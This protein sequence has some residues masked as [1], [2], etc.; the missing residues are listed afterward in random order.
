M[1]PHLAGKD[2]VMRAISAMEFAPPDAIA[3]AG[4]GKRPPPD[5]EQ[6]RPAGA[7]GGSRAP[8]AACYALLSE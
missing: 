3:R 4:H 8:A 2:G 5:D 1:T 7:I 6:K